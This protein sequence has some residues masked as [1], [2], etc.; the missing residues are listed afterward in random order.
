[1]DAVPSVTLLLT[2]NEIEK[3]LRKEAHR[4][5]FAKWPEVKEKADYCRT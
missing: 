2:G 3:V 4:P 1:M 5:A